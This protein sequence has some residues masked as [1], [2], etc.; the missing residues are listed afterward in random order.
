MEIR[1]NS[2]WIKIPVVFLLKLH[3][4]KGIICQHAFSAY[5]EVDKL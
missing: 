1:D 2:G 5:K 4:D 3:Y